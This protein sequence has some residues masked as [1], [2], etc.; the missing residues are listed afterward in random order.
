MRKI[1]IFIA[2]I[3]FTSLLFSCNRKSALS[4]SEGRGKNSYD[5][6][7][8]DFLYTEGIK[9]KLM[10][11]AGDALKYLEKCVE[12]NPRS[13]ASYHQMAQISLQLGN[14]AQAKKYAVK[15]AELDEQ[16]LWYMTFLGGIYYQERNL[17]SALIYFEKT[18]RIQ[19]DNNDVKVTLAG[20]YTELGDYKKA[21]EIYSYFIEK[22]GANENISLMIV[23]NMM[24]SGDLDGAELIIKELLKENPAEILYNGILAEIYRKKGLNDKAEEVYKKLLDLDSTN[25]Q[26]LLSLSDFM[27]AEKKYD[28]L[29]VLLNI[30]AVNEK[31]TMENKIALLSK[32]IDTEDIVKNKGKELEVA[33]RIFEE[34]EKN[35]DFINLIR[36]ELY[37]K[38]G[39]KEDAITRLE[40]IIIMNPNIYF[41]WERLL[42]LYSDT[43]NFDKLYIRGKE[44]ATRFN[45]SYPAKILY[46]SA[47]MEKKLY[48]EALEELRKAKILAGNQ[49]EMLMQVVSMEADIYYRKG[50]YD[51]S[52]VLFKEALEYNPDDVII[53]N[54]YAYY[55]AEQNKDIKEAEKMIKRVIEKEK[56]NNT[57][58]DTYAW[59][60]YKSGKTRDAIKV[61]E[62]IMARDNKPDPDWFEHYGYMMKSLRKCEVAINYWKR[63]LELEPERIELINAIE[64][65]KR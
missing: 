8:F 14:T 39:R 10:G 60:L 38:M 15:A 46:A 52:F 59:V 29:F 21:N 4:L 58:L 47:A 56:D 24:N 44:C 28:D 63:A 48:E 64:S 2:V 62:D 23:K 35:K 3:F 43:R 22:Y 51:K 37:Q 54:N 32:L 7:T 26:T 18:V 42:I 19:P 65:C 9:Q 16:N 17:D 55:L 36:P 41:A 13:D 61:M 31:V 6:A 1:S 5:V 30:I 27:I 20:I 50:E 49:N 34:G 11:N 25:P 57:F 45:M 12:M 53:L 33:L 40:E